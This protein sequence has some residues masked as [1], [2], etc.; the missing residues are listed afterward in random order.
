[1][2]ASQG[3]RLCGQKRRRDDY[4]IDDQ[5]LPTAKRQLCFFHRT[6]PPRLLLHF[7]LPTTP[8]TPTIPTRH[9]RIK[10]RQITSFE[11]VLNNDLQQAQKSLAQLSIDPCSKFPQFR[12]LP[13][14]LRLQIWRETWE[15]RDVKLARR[16]GLWTVW[17]R[18]VP[19]NLGIVHVHHLAT[20]QHWNVHQHGRDWCGYSMIPGRFVTHTRSTTRPP[21]S[22]WVNR[23]SRGETLRHFELAFALPDRCPYT[24][25]QDQSS[26]HFG[27]HTFAYFNFDLD[28]LVF[29]LHRQLADAFS[30]LDL[31][32]LRRVSIPELAPALPRFTHHGF[33][34]NPPLPRILPKVDD[35]D[36]VVRYDEFKYVWRLLRKW[37]PSLREIHLDKFSAC[38]NYQFTERSR[39]LRY[40]SSPSLRFVKV[41]YCYLCDMIQSEVIVNY[42][43]LGMRSYYGPQQYMDRI[44]EGHDIIQ[45]VFEKQTLVIG[46]VKGGRG[47]QDEDVTVTYWA[48]RD[49]GGRN[50][51]VDL[52][53]RGTDWAVVRRQV[54]ARTL[55]RA[56]GPPRPNEAMVYHFNHSA[57]LR[58]GWKTRWDCAY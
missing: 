5:D 41:P 27:S 44:L 45:P 9:P 22:L 13:T 46:R 26:K 58:N 54:V 11:G 50:D 4:N 17:D 38:E 20:R 23:E 37:F 55:E 7:R 14:E 43:R 18:T 24:G 21:T 48:I 8:T 34:L 35:E 40:F 56:F 52:E 47:E 6:S 29:P 31:S 51:V 36:Q 16:S 12:R 25:I 1:M 3:P 10:P 15:H 28:K 19:N 42:P 30:Q 57:F 39:E 53:A 32:R 33:P 2:E 49:S